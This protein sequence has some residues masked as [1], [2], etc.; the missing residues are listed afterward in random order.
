[1]GWE[2]VMGVE[3]MLVR[4][5]CGVRERSFGYTTSSILLS[6]PT[7]RPFLLALEMIDPFDESISC[8]VESIVSLCPT[9]R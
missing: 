1:M 2:R 5:V 6:F 3:V 7:Y 9:M 8:V 4:A